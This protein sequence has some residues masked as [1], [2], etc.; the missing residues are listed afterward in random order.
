MLADRDKYCRFEANGFILE[1]MSEIPS[2][3]KTQ[4]ACR[5]F[6]RL[7]LTENT[8][9]NLQIEL[10]NGAMRKRSQNLLS[11]RLCEKVRPQECWAR[12]A[13]LAHLVGRG[14]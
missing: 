8:P 10:F 6:A 12:A 2:E 14:L 5:V 7:Y 9:R 4:E 13:I 11:Q 1:N 3:C